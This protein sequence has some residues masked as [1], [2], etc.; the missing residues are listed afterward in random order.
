TGGIETAY[1]ASVVPGS[2]LR[3]ALPPGPRGALLQVPFYLD[4]ADRYYTRC[5]RRYGDPFTEPTLWGPQVVTA[6]PEGVR[7]ILALPPGAFDNFLPVLGPV[8]GPA[9]V[10]VTNGDVHRRARRLL[11]PFFSRGP[12]DALAPEIHALAAR[13]AA[14]FEPGRRYEALALGR[15]ITFDVIMRIVFGAGAHGRWSA[16]RGRIADLVDHV[17]PVSVV[18]LARPW[19]RRTLGR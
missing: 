2:P 11:T 17:S 9:S 15:A 5:L 3:S 10:L 19:F 8:F 12:L 14:S 4:R 7:A 16:L 13:H 1:S 18:P 6:R